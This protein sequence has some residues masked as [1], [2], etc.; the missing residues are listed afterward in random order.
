[1]QQSNRQISP[2]RRGKNVVRPRKK[3]DKMVETKEAWFEVLS[4]AEFSQK[5]IE[6]QSNTNIFKG[7]LQNGRQNIFMLK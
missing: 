7:T 1:M 2:P 3:T 5:A 4:K 6:Q